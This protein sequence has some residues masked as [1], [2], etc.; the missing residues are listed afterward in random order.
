MSSPDDTRDL[1]VLVPGRNDE[2]AVRSL[3]NRPGELGIR[4]IKF[5]THVHS[6][7]DPGCLRESHSF[8]SPL[9][10]QFAHA[11][12]MFDRIGSG[13]ESNSAE[14]LETLVVGQLEASGWKGRAGAIVIDP[15]LEAWVWADSANVDRHL[16]WS[17][18]SPSLREWL[19]SVGQVAIGQKFVNPTKAVELAL[20]KARIPRS[21]SVYADLAG[22]VSLRRCQDPAFA[23]FKEVLQN[24]FPLDT[25]PLIR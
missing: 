4:P 3:L 25:G 9:S 19:T 7:R 15:E 18:R 12:V 1:V 11:L 6:R 5:V 10:G 17:G 2:A 20:R 16:G 24:W 23:R 13:R 22:T 14:E 8:L 21:S